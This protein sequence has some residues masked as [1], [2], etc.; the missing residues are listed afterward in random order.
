MTERIL[1]ALRAVPE[2][3]LSGTVDAVAR[4]LYE[5]LHLRR[6]GGSA[7][8]GAEAGRA[9]AEIFGPRHRF[10]AGW[11]VVSRD[12]GQ[13]DDPSHVVVEKG[14]LHVR[15]HV[16][17]IAA[18]GRVRLPA[19]RNRFTPGFAAYLSADPPA[20]TGTRIYLGT[21]YEQSPTVAAAAADVIAAT[22]ER[23]VIKCLTSADEYPRSDAITIYVSNAD[24][25]AVLEALNV[26][27]ITVRLLP[28][29]S[30]SVFASGHPSG[31]AWLEGSARR[32]AGEERSL[33]VARAAL[34]HDDVHD[35]GLQDRLTEEFLAAGI[36]AGEPWRRAARGLS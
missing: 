9:A 35:P 16:D 28:E 8:A 31:A 20:E 25:D 22:A 15:V 30:R 34:A 6:S 12:S 24:R 5:H 14:G 21:S 29:V 33:C 3:A 13:Q 1:Q 10:E 26:P 27:D 17:D 11:R 4:K 18:D 19:L 7:A 36:D 2:E 23:F 32:S